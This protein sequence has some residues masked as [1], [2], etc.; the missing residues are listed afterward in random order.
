MAAEWT[1]GL[2]SPWR[3]LS[4]ITSDTTQTGQSFCTSSRLVVV[5]VVAMCPLQR[6]D[7][8][9]LKLFLI[10][11]EWVMVHAIQKLVTTVCRPAYFVEPTQL[12]PHPG[13]GH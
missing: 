1:P 6:N 8:E 13:A 4:W 5:V 2:S 7:M 12:F 3:R 10:R 9:S 11:T